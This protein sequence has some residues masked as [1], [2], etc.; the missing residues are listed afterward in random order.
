MSGKRILYIATADA[1]GHLMRCQ[2]LVKQLRQ[3]GITV[4]VLTTSQAG[5]DFLSAFEIDAVVFSRHYYI[6]FDDAHN[7]NHA[8]TNLRVASY[9]LLPH[10]LLKD[11]FQLSR[12]LPEYDL[13][14]NDSFQPAALFLPVLNRNAR[15]KIVHIFGDTL[16]DSVTNHLDTRWP[17]FCADIYR[18]SIKQ[19]I[20]LS[21][22]R[23]VHAFHHQD[24][25]EGRDSCE[26][27]LPTPL[28]S[29]P[30]TTQSHQKKT[31]VVYLNPHFKC[32]RRAYAMQQTLIKQ[33]YEVHAVGEGVASTLSGWEKYDTQLNSRIATADLLVAGAGMA[34]SHLAYLFK[35]PF[36]AIDTEQ[37]EQKRNLKHLKTLSTVYSL[38]Y[39]RSP[40]NIQNR[41]Q[42][43]CQSR[44]SKTRKHT[45]LAQIN[46]TIQ[47][48]LDLWVN[49]IKS[50]A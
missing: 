16:Q 14:I 43:I 23:L 41:L 3:H 7:I 42:A 34:A 11:L 28:A 32:T 19:Q 26:I 18:Y 24:R 8:K 29:L 2:I 13:V 33:G 4:D 9:Q 48:N 50:L 40:L 27:C 10:G 25:T 35:I 36:I 15:A 44:A 39:S 49:T 31:A 20:K 37:P 17:K 21:H 1:R 38:D 6:E 47:G 46:Q 30:S 12:K 45:D 5:A 22:A